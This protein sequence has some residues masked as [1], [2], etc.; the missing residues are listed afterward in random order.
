M[1]DGSAAAYS[2]I[3]A[4]STPVSP[5]IFTRRMLKEYGQNW[6]GQAIELRIEPL[7]TGSFTEIFL[8]VIWPNGARISAIIWEPHGL[9]RGPLKYLKRLWRTFRPDTVVV[10]QT[11]L[12]PTPVFRVIGNGVQSRSKPNTF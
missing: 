4:C 7:Q 3:G 11:S 12:P 6:D 9:R 8:T 2:G 1:K 5:A 10:A